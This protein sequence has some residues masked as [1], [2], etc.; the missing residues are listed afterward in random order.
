MERVPDARP[1]EARPL[2]TSDGDG[3]GVAEA[4][5]RLCDMAALRRPDDPLLVRFLPLYYSELPAGDVDDRKLDDVYAVA[6]AH[7]ALARVRAPGQSVVRVV[8]PDRDRDGWESAHSVLL[9]VTDDMPFLV[10]T[11][12][13]VLER[14]GLGVHLLVHPMLSVR[15]DAAHRLTDVASDVVRPGGDG[16]GVI[17][18]WTQIEIDRI[19][20]ATARRLEDAIVSAVD[21]VRRAVDDFPA[22]RDRMEALGAVDPLLPWLAEGQFVFLGAADYDIAPTEG[23]RC[24]PAASSGWPAP[25]RASLRRARWRGPAPS[26]SP[27]PTTSPRSSGPSDARSSP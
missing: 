17:E 3:H 22:M 2:R 13:M 4:L 16:G 26:S 7:L 25:S 9:V 8:S 5:G 15:R 24:A 18:A 1:G 14:H 19:D 11:M 21:D 10:D 12:R 20:E 27:A 23:S 6:V